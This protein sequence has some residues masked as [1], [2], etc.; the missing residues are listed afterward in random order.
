MNAMEARKKLSFFGKWITDESEYK[1]LQPT[2]LD[3]A[4]LAAEL[5][6]RT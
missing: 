3:A 2:A 6:T 4:N 5:R 1:K